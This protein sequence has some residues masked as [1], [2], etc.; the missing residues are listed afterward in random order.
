MNQSK[1]FEV[2]KP[3]LRNQIWHYTS[4]LVHTSFY[5]RI[6]WSQATHK[7]HIF[8]SHNSGAQ[9]IF[10]DSFSPDV[11]P[12]PP[13]IS[14]GGGG[15]GGGGRWRTW[16][17]ERQHTDP[18]FRG[19]LKST[20]DPQWLSWSVALN[21]SRKWE[22]CSGVRRKLMTVNGWLVMKQISNS[23]INTGINFGATGKE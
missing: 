16:Q 22:A 10:L 23:W 2:S 6:P 19:N 18:I 3:W 4:V 14:G 21:C 12:P 9:L 20:A 11:F 15:W 5:K 1:Y 8:S 17:H 7:Q 13:S